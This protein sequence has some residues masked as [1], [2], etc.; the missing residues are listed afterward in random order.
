MENY[1]IHRKI[2]VKDGYEITATLTDGDQTRTK[3]FFCPGDKEPIDE[4]L[5]KKLDRM[6][7]R[8][9]EKNK[10]VPDV[11]MMESEV[12]ELLRKKDLLK[13]DEKLRDLKNKKDLCKDKDDS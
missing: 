5:N 4:S 13:K 8:F 3:L 9:I 6:L 2:K 12:E 11:Q 7:D 10:I 1:K